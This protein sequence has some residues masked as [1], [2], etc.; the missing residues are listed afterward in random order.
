MDVIVANAL[1]AY[2]AASSVDSS[3][4]DS[5][6]S[7]TGPSTVDDESQSMIPSEENKSCLNETYAQKRLPFKKQMILQWKDQEITIQGNEA[8][9]AESKPIDIHVAKSQE[10]ENAYV[11]T[12][13]SST[14]KNQRVSPLCNQ[15]LVEYQDQVKKMERFI[16]S[17]CEYEL[18]LLNEAKSVREKR[19]RMVY[20]LKYLKLQ[21]LRR[22]YMRSAKVKQDFIDCSNIFDSASRAHQNVSFVDDDFPL[23][24]VF[25]QVPISIRRQR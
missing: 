9:S 16:R 22:S 21:V 23:P 20:R 1:T 2:I 24:P 7:P 11:L 3:A 6:A 19:N 25:N 17:A 5:D 13:K 10:D 15:K 8:K 18:Q 4:T 12:P 14:P